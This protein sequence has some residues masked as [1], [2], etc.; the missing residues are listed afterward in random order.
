ML[1]KRSLIKLL[2]AVPIVWILVM[3]IVSFKDSSGSSH[4]DNEKIKRLE[5]QNNELI[6]AAARRHEEEKRKS[7]AAQNE[8]QDHPEEE[9]A[10][11]QEQQKAKAGKLA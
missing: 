2:I 11:A 10:K 1:R 8:D 6:A 4:V 7:Q 5:A 3:F 9:Q